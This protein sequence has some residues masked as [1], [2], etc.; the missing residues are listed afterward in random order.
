MKDKAYQES[1]D[2][3]H[4]ARLERDEA[5]RTTEKIRNEIS[6]VYDK[7]FELKVKK[8]SLREALGCQQREA[9]SKK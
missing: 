3:A 5:Q 1:A 7:I 9:S 8:E 6:T 4:R 2:E